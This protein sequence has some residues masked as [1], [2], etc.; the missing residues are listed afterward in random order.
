MEDRCVRGAV[1]GR[2]E[3]YEGIVWAIPLRRLW[4]ASVSVVGYS[5]KE[6]AEGA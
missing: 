2:R 1:W 6:L 3:Y 5:E 4:G